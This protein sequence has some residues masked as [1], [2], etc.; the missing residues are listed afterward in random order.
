[1]PDELTHYLKALALAQGQLGAHSVAPRDYVYLR[2]DIAPKMV[3]NGRWP[4]FERERTVAALTQRPSDAV[5]AHQTSVSYAFPCAYL[6]QSVALKLGLV[7]RAPPLLAFY[8]GRLLTFAAAAFLF[9]NAI[10]TAPFGKGLFTLVGLLPETFQQ[11]ASFSYDA[12]HL[13]GVS[14]FVAY[15]LACADQPTPLSRRQRWTW[16]ALSLSGSVLKPGYT[17]LA[18]FVFLLGE[19]QLGS[20]RTY[21]MY[22]LGTLAVNVTVVA[23]GR[24]LFPSNA[25]HGSADPA[26]Q[27]AHVLAHPFSFV[28]T[29]L[30]TL[31]VHFGDLCA[32]LVYRSGPLSEG[33]PSF[34]YALALLG[35]LLWACS[36]DED[37]R[38][39]TR[40]RLVL[41]AGCA[42]QAVLVFLSMYLACNTVGHPLV[43]GVQ[44]RYFL[45]L[46]APCLLAFQRSGFRL[47]SRWIRGRPRLAFL[48]LALPLLAL[49]AWALYDLY[50]RGDPS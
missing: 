8:F 25:A 49:A 21:W 10:R 36:Q 40:Q 17:L 32:G 11:S 26:A 6:P 43:K 5:V 3:A 27:A 45:V 35:S 29:M 46:V 47:G 9:W 24:W 30:R 28:L 38:L 22:A 19:R 1:V 23:L 14:W 15:A 39:S 37:V 44:G 20:R 4:G 16:F 50:Y 41:L 7:A 2:L 33:L 31:H 18:S 13:G 12:L 34:G 48:A 42:G